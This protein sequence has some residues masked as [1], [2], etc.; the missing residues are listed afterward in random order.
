MHKIAT[1]LTF[2]LALT[3]GAQVVDPVIMTV[4]GKQVTR[5]EFEYSFNKN[6]NPEKAV[7][8]RAIEDYVPMFINYKLKV[9]A[10]E[11]A[12]LDTLSSFK[13]EF[14]TYRDMQLTPYLVDS[15]FIDSI[16]TSIYKDSEKQLNG[17]DLLKPSH[18]LI[19]VPA[20]ATETEKEIYRQRIDSIYSALQHGA[21]FATLAKEKSQDP[22]SALQGGKLPWIGPGSTLKEFE[23][24]AYALKVG[25]FSKPVETAVGFHIIRMDER[26][27]LEPYAVLRPQI[28]AALKQQGIDEVSA[29]AKIKKIVAASKGRLTRELV[30]DSVF[31]ANSSD[32]NLRYLVQEYH[33]GL[34]LY[35]VSKREVWDKV[36][37]DTSALEQQF[38]K[39][40]K[41]Y[42]WTEPRFKGFVIHA[43]DEKKMKAAQTILKKTADGDWKKAIRETFNKDSVTVTVSGPYL[44]KKG[45]NRYVDAEVFGGETVKSNSNY[46]YS[47][48]EGQVLKQPKSYLD[49]KS[50]VINDVQDKRTEEWVKRLRNEYSF[51]VNQDVV[52]TVN[53]H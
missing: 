18:I 51:N 40:K 34:L 28:F 10:A 5:S 26:K 31:V 12:R 8:I 22:G 30:L 32:L 7:D 16:A 9:A 1:L 25:E 29:E 46:P 39:N 36:A 41:Q 53:K 33:D 38:K 21:D 4:N 6:G 43:K 48:V 50:A 17:H 24:A 13:K 20:S 37:Q 19:L 45:E 35:E 44:V 2:S 42:A 3:V 47:G 27:P 11:A 15:T 23:D 49:V 52:K 14:M